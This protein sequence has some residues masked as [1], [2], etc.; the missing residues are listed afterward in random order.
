VSWF[1]D[2]LEYIFLSPF[3]EEIGWRGFLLPEMESKYGNFTASLLVGLIWGVWHIPLRIHTAPP[4]SSPIAFAT[5][6]VVEI[7]GVS[8]VLAWLYNA[9]G[10]SVV[11]CTIFH[12]AFNAAADSFVTPEANAYGGLSAIEGAV[13]SMCLLAAIVLLADKTSS[14]SVF[15]PRRIP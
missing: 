15:W 4:R 14:K 7:V 9:S 5:L 2:V 3:W 11:P 13:A 10:G 1:T 12:A 6:F 8:V